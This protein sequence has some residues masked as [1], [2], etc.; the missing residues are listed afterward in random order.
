M[1]KSL[2]NR[3]LDEIHQTI[4]AQSFKEFH[5]EVVIQDST[6]KLNRNSQLMTKQKQS[7][8][9]YQ[10]QSDT[11]KENLVRVTSLKSMSGPQQNQV[12]GLAAESVSSIKE[13][14][15]RRMS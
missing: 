4:N 7:A 6:N 8:L 14:A 12:R 15:A 3:E 9:T 10:T 13:D 2:L 11:Y 1:D 5:N